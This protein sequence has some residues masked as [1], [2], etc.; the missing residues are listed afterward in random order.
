M[1]IYN[2]LTEKKEELIP[3]N[4][5][6]VKIYACGI[7]V[8]GEAHL[9]HARQAIVFNM[10][11]EY[12]R[13]KNFTVI[14]VRNYTDI[15]DKIIKQAKEL[16]I[17][18]LELSDARIKETDKII[19]RIVTSDADFKPRVSTYIPQII[20]FIQKLIEKGNAYKTA[21][22]DIYFSVRSF[23]D[24]GKLSNRKIEDLL[25]G[26]RKDT[27]EGKSDLLDF[28]LWKVTIDDEFGWD[29]PWGKGRPG[30]HIECSAMI[31]SILGKQIDIHGG[32]KDL[33][34]PHHENEIAQSEALNGCELSKFW[35]HNGLITVDGQK[36]GKSA[37]NF[38]TIKELLETYNASVLR[39]SV[40]S[41]H[42]SSPLEFNDQSLKI[43]EC[44]LYYFYNSLLQNIEIN[45][46]PQSMKEDTEIL[47]IFDDCMNDDFNTSKFF[48]ELFI[49]FSKLNNIKDKCI[50]KKNFESLYLSLKKIY[51][52]TGL[53]INIEDNIRELRSKYLRLLDIDEQEIQLSIEIRKEAKRIK[54][55]AKADE[56][57]ND[58]SNRGILLMDNINETY[59]DIKQ[60]YN[61]NNMNI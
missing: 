22:G 29:A 11:T 6:T 30:W 17:E 5:N 58:L 31:D 15:D 34:F 2:V 12:L 35:I 47:K 40:L 24:Y 20:E 16:Q 52:I 60:L 38:K 10:I 50:R 57:R 1:K 46:I 59:W 61:Q 41:N 44:N 53:F 4:E 32:G 33:I 51:P 26:V 36:M 7:T 8:N 21:Q 25:H 23:S 39:F 9:G 42:Y 3:I 43:A 28:A 19:N 54:N 49:L 18:P 27:K 14:Y 13:Y 56:I 55:Y 45:F 48:S 37:N